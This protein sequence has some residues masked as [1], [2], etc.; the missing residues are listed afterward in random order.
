MNKP[1]FDTKKYVVATFNN[2]HAIE[3]AL[4]G[5]SEVNEIDFS[6]IDKWTLVVRLKNKND[7]ELRETVSAVIKKSK[8]YVETDLS[9]INAKKKEGYSPLDYPIFG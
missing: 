9:H 2:P 1:K 7:S 5:L 3:S 8:G 4:A 6:A